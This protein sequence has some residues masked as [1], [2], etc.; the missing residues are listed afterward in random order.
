MRFSIKK[1]PLGRRADG[2]A[3]DNQTGSNGWSCPM[4]SM[5]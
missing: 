1:Y 5:R 3:N 2:N 4:M